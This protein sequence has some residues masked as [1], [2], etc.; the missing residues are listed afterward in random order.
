MQ[1][2]HDILEVNEYLISGLI[3]SQIDSWFTGAVPRSLSQDFGPLRERHDLP[4]VLQRARGALNDPAQVTLQH[5]S[6]RCL[7][8]YSLCIR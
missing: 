4:S 8:L 2:R 3:N 1:S 6:P 7:G 5:V